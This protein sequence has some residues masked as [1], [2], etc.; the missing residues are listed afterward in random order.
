MQELIAAPTLELVNTPSQKGLDASILRTPPHNYEAEQAL[1]GALLYNNASYEKV[2]EILRAE[3]FADSVHGRIYASIGRLIE[4]GQIADPITLRDYFEQEQAL[5]EIGGAKYLVQLAAS[6]V[7]IVNSADYAKLIHDLYLRRQLI[8]IGE[9]VVNEAFAF[10][11]DQDATS[12]IEKAEQRLFDLATVGDM[13][14]GFIAFEDALKI[15]IDMAE[16]AFQR[17]S[18]IVG[19]TSGLKDLDKMLGG[20]HPSDLVIL[21]ARPSMGKTGLALCLAFNAAKEVMFG[22]AKTGASVAFFSLE[23]SSEQL[24]TRLL[25]QEVQV[26]SDKIRRG[27][28]KDEDFPSFVDAARRLSN[29]PL[30]IDD[31]PALSVTALRTRARRL[32]RQRG[33]GL[34]VVD[35]LQL[36]QGPAGKSNDT[37][38]QEVSD[39]T[40]AL[41]ALAKELDV[42]VIALSQLSRAVE[43]R[44]DKRPQLADLRESGSIEQDADVVMFIYREEYY[45]ERKEPPEGTEKHREW[46]EKMSS[47][48][49][50]AELIV[51]KQRHGPIGTVKTFFEGPLI[52]FSDLA[53]DRFK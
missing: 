28:L 36:L 23:M 1:L 29:L 4:R 15:S 33:L 16:I 52:K 24:A 10:D 34:I 3:H 13:E 2:A 30:Y 46:Q 53:H 5:E 19:V 35:Y 12:Q 38:V 49:N 39:I 45:E 21:A 47:I 44:E 9:D 43:Q 17:D 22:D 14:R 6:V 40:R 31:T 41:K 42:P 7:S 48:Y 25:S 27:E 20:F 37:R 50:V 11:L 8:N 51:A 18:H 26:S 32:K